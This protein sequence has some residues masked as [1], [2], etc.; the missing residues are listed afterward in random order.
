[1]SDE[2]Y[3]SLSKA[4]DRSLS[5][6]MLDKRKVDL[7]RMGYPKDLDERVGQFGGRVSY[8]IY[9]L[10]DPNRSPVEKNFGKAVT[11]AGKDF[12]DQLEEQDYQKYRNIRN[13]MGA[14]SASTCLWWTLAPYIYDELVQ[15]LGES[16]AVVQVLE[17][18][19]AEE[20]DLEEICLLGLEDYNSIAP[21]GRTFT[22]SE[23][24][25]HYS[26]IFARQEAKR[27]VKEAFKL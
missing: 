13:L 21:N 25:E 18:G 10:L 11:Y 22:L 5:W 4:N 3:D 26:H 9:R 19:N 7:T 6:G 17:W 8:H 12:L 1:M 15:K 14:E 23:K 27:L 24:P 2:L 16:D 20:L